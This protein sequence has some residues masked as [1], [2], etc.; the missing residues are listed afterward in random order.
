MG[1]NQNP[2][3][4]ELSECRGEA[5][6]AVITES[7]LGRMLC[8]LGLFHFPVWSAL[9]AFGLSLYAQDLPGMAKPSSF[10]SL[11]GFGTKP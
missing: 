7:P 1:R 11:K 5:K 4:K 6:A 8:Y 9:L 2:P 3:A 10:E